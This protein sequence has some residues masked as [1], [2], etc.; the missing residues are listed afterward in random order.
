METIV[1]QDLTVGTSISLNVEQKKKFFYRLN[2]CTDMIF[3]G[4]NIMDCCDYICDTNGWCY[5]T[6]QEISIV[7]GFYEYVNGR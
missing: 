2:Q 7:S 4:D 3:S 1:A 6:S 5:L